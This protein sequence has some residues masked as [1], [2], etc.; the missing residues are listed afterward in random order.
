[1]STIV[2]KYLSEKNENI[3]LITTIAVIITAVLGIAAGYDFVR[4][5]LWVPKVE[6]ISVD[7]ETGTCQLK[8][9]GDE[10][11]LIGDDTAFAGG[12]WGVRF[13]TLT[14]G[15][16]QHYHTVEMVKDGM[17]YKTLATRPA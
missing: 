16:E 3:R 15:G 1:M 5:N 8:I 13:G 4:N 9:R 2:D 17:V 11:T 14:I 6:L 12:A 10:R 7:F